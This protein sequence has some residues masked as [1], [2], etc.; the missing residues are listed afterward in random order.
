M[1]Q[2]AYQTVTLRRLPSGDTIQISISTKQSLTILVNKDSK[3]QT[4][5]LSA[6]NPF[7]LTPK[8]YGTSGTVAIISEA[9]WTMD[10]KDIPSTI[11]TWNNL[12]E[13]T[14]FASPIDTS[15]VH[16][17]NLTFK[18][19][20]TLNGHIYDVEK[21][22]NLNCVEVSENSYW[23]AIEASN[24]TT[25]DENNAQTELVPHLYL[26]N[27]EVDKSKYTVKWYKTKAGGDE[28]I[29]ASQKDYWT[30]SS[31]GT[32]TVMRDGVEGAAHFEAHFYIG[33]Q[34]VE[35]EGVAL[36]DVADVFQ[37]DVQG[38][39]YASENGEITLTVKGY[40]SKTGAKIPITSISLVAT[41]SIRERTY[42]D[43]YKGSV[44]INTDKTATI[45]VQERYWRVPWGD[46]QVIGQW[47]ICGDS[48]A[49]D[50]YTTNISE[51]TK[52]E[53]ILLIGATAEI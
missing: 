27:N 51:A 29:T 7:I 34:E 26:G 1:S 39:T 43:A 50:K 8:V 32:L 48:A 15:N 17:F 19:K 35:A 47:C 33:G 49:D 24:G 46:Q 30:L 4:P 2:T 6:Q 36:V 37:I 41:D 10:G 52:C 12:G 53:M 16:P 25:L 40:N 23:G 3:V 38:D 28:A 45:K 5:Q 13:L 21:S 42:N 14:I 20:A 31:N 44:T 22:T 9:K 18:A 11:A